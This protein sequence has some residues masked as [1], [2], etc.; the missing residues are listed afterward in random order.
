MWVVVSIH[1]TRSIQLQ[2]SNTRL[3]LHKLILLGV[4]VQYLVGDFAF[5][6]LKGKEALRLEKYFSRKE[7]THV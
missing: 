1:A 6:G 7:I 2:S 3:G 5:Y 4:R